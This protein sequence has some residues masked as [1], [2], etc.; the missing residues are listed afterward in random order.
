MRSAGREGRVKLGHGGVV[1]GDNVIVPDR[2]AD[3]GDGPG[4]DRTQLDP[5]VADVRAQELPE[6]PHR[7]PGTVEL[8]FQ[9]LQ[10]PGDEVGAPLRVLG[11]EDGLHVGQ[12]HVQFTEP[13][14]DLGGGDL[15]RP[16]STGNR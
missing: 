11:R 2:T 5:Q 6:R 16:C 8:V 4:G 12:R 1:P 15:V 14:N 3:R 7:G 10:V 9:A 13:V